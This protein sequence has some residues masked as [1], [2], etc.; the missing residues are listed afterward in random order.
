M[1]T[2]I[3][4]TIVLTNILYVRETLDVREIKGNERIWN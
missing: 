3:P 2:K 1:K 4:K